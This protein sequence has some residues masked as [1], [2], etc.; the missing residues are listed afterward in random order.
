MCWCLY[1]VRLPLCILYVL[2]AYLHV[3]VV[4]VFTGDKYTPY[5][6]TR[7]LFCFILSS[8]DMQGRLPV[9]ALIVAPLLIKSPDDV[10]SVAFDV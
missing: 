10:Q 1:Y 7:A 4:I 3:Y 9:P 5:L 2:C 6:K 8:P